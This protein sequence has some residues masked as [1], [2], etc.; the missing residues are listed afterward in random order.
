ML[1]FPIIMGITS[2]ATF[3]LGFLLLANSRKVNPIANRY[4]GL[5]VITLGLAI[6]EIPLFY[7]KIQ[8]K[9]PNLFEMIGLIRFLTAPFLYCSI[10]YF[11]SFSKKFEKKNLWH[12][13]PF[14]TFLIFRLPFFVTGKNI[15]FSYEIGRVVF[16]ILQ[17]ALPLQA[18]IYW[19]LSFRRLQKHIKNIH[20]FS[21]STEQIDL[22]W[23]KYFLLILVFIIIAWL[24]LVFFN[25]NSLI[26]LTP[27]IY[28]LSVFFLA[29]F[30]LQQKEIFDFSKS[31]IN[32][33][34]VIKED[35]KQT[36]KRVSESRI[37]ELNEKLQ[38]LMDLEKVYLENDLSLPK[39]A[40]RMNAS[41]NEVSFVIN[42]LYRDNFY[43]FINK[44]RVEEAKILLLSEKYNQLNILGIAYES[45]FNSKTTFNTTFKKHTGFSPTEFVK[46]NS[47]LEKKEA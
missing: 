15:E 7:Q 11:T 45:G 42:E 18:I 46:T 43:N 41:C 33:L 27:F 25:L 9:H 21:S 10:L 24:N 20:Q 2:G 23:L 35:K 8:I 34:S 37:I 6:I 38:M 17:T 5:F 36:Q 16:F 32:D 26:E 39:L 40:K 30:S 13:L 1:N 47:I 12:F 29:Y 44:Y 22:S 31:E 3:L 14:L 4:L 19:C 28:L